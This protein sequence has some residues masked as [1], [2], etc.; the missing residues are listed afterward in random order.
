MHQLVLHQLTTKK[1]VTKESRE[2]KICR[3]NENQKL[4]IPILLLLG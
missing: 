3:N 1:A 2:K 4:E